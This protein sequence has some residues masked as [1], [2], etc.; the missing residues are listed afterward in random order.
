M[1]TVKIMAEEGGPG[2]WLADAAAQTFAELPVSARLRSRLAAWNERYDRDCDPAA[3]E[4]PSCARFDFIAFANEGFALAKAVKRALPH[5]RVL[6]WDE[7]LEWRYWMSRE[8]R[9]YDRAQHE[10]EITAAIAATSD[11]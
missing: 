3:Y 2:Y 10:Y 5:W 1:P 6:Y 9:R 11:R 4:D 7:A 8:P